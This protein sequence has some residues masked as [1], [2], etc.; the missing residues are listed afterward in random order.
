[1]DPSAG[2]SIHEASR[3]EDSHTHTPHH[4]KH[5]HSTASAKAIPPTTT[6]TAAAAAAANNGDRAP[7]K[8]P[9][10][11]EGFFGAIGNVAY[12]A[13]APFLKLYDSFADFLRSLRLTRVPGDWDASV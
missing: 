7:L 9:K 13:V 8:A 4:T 10:A 2:L 12:S 5:T 1:M 11:S 6:T 3:N